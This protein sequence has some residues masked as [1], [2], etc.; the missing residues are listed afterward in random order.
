[1]SQPKHH[2][3]QSVLVDV[4][5]GQIDRTRGF[6][7]QN[8]LAMCETCSESVGELQAPG[9]SWYS[10]STAIEPSPEIWG[11]L[12]AAIQQP[13]V[14]GD[15]GL[16]LPMTWSAE[17]IPWRGPVAWR[18]PGIRGTQMALLSKDPQTGSFL[19]A[20]RGDSDRNFPAHLHLGLEEVL[21]LQGGY[22]DGL[23]EADAGDFVAYEPGSSHRPWTEPDEGCVVLSRIEKGVRFLGWRGWAARILAGLGLM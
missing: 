10:G 12:E 18:S 5:A 1:M 2:P 6:L 20:I 8:H 11:R 22:R 4:A 9:S 19:V 23:F 14:R 15:G 17:D 7:V 3:P 21:V 16:P 13:I